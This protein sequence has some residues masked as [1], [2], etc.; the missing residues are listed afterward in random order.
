MCYKAEMLVYQKFEV[1]SSVCYLQPDTDVAER[2]SVKSIGWEISWSC[3][4]SRSVSHLTALLE[5]KPDKWRCNDGNQGVHLKSELTGYPFNFL[6]HNLCVYFLCNHYLYM[7]NRTLVPDVSFITILSTGFNKD[8]MFYCRPH[9]SPP[10]V[11]RTVGLLMSKWCHK[12]GKSTCK[13]DF[14]I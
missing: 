13:K 8:R 7:Y 9:Q 1:H 14:S 2:L 3:W 6:S 11:S 10:G 5:V 12:P 4:A